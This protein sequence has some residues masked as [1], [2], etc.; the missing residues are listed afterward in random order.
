V[1]VGDEGTSLPTCHLIITLFKSGAVQTAVIIMAIGI[2]AVIAHGDV[3]TRR[4]P[5]VLAATITILGL[6]RMILDGDPIAAAHTFVAS[7]ALL[8]GGF[9]LFWRGV[10]GGGDAK[11]VAAMAVLIGYHNLLAFLVLMSLCGGGLAL[12]ILAREKLH[13][14]RSILS[15]PIIIPSAPQAARCTVPYGVAIAAAGVITLIVENFAVR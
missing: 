3:R 13:R 6:V 2:L 11:L 8:A 9:L 4:I 5:N 7:A 1:A 12:A 15:C 14:Q 10:F